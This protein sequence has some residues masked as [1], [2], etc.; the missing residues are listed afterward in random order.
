MNPELEEKLSALLDGELSS[1]EAEGLRSELERSPELRQRM[2]ELEAVNQV[3]R[4]LPGPQASPELRA[5]LQARIQADVSPAPSVSPSRPPRRPRRSFA[6]LATAATAAAIVALVLLRDP[7]LIADDE[8]GAPLAASNPDD[9]ELE[10][11]VVAL[12]GSDPEDA[13]LPNAADEDLEVIEVLDLLAALDLEASS[14]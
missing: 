12:L 3:V 4:A 10:A 7:A 8:P 6:W 5:S 14:G 11:I 2:A 9:S 13:G 1:T